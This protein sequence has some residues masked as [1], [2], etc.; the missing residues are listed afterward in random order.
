[1]LRADAKIVRI[2][3]GQHQPRLS[4]AQRKFNTLIKK[5]D[6]QKQRL[7]VWQETIP[8]Y[9][10]RVAEQFIP[11]RETFGEHQVEMVHLL[12]RQHRDK[13]FSRNQKKKIAHLIRE[14]CSELINAHERE[15]LKPIYN[16]YSD[17]DFDTEDQETTALA[18]DFIKSMLE[19]ELGIPLDD[20]DVDVTSPEKMAAFVQEKLDERQRQAEERRNRRKKTAKQRAREARQQEEE[21]KLGKSLQAVYRQLVTALH[22]DREQDPAERERKTGL[23][24]QVTVA[25]GKKDLLQLLELQLAVEQIDQSSINTIADDRLKYYNRILQGQLEQLQ[26]E[27]TEIEFMF[28][29]QAGLAPYDTLSPG[30]LMQLLHDDIERLGSEI[31]RIREDLAAFQ[32]ANRLKSWLKEYRIPIETDGLMDGLDALFLGEDLPPFVFR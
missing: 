15:E 4:P 26:L 19:R 30:R 8:R 18:G 11:L 5:I 12:D 6:S 17:L 27:V 24:Q 29:Q 21:T 10:Q 7:A 1:M 31:H 22:P 25:Y 9:Q 13:R 23:M 28:R 32:D 2:E 16:R 3:E 14:M 20:E